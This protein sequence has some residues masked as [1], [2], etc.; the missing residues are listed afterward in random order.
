M[1]TIIHQSGIQGFV[2]SKKINTISVIENAFNSILP[3]KEGIFSGQYII[4]FNDFEYDLQIED[5]GSSV[6]IS[7]GT[8]SF[9]G[10][11][12]LILDLNESNISSLDVFAYDEDGVEYDIP[13]VEIRENNRVR[14]DL[15]TAIIQTTKDLTHIEIL[16]ISS[17]GIQND[18]DLVFYKTPE[19]IQRDVSFPYYNTYY[20]YYSG[21]DSKSGEPW[22]MCSIAT[23]PPADFALD[24][25]TSESCKIFGADVDF[26]R[27]EKLLLTTDG[28]HFTSFIL[29]ALD[30]GGTPIIEI[31]ITAPDENN[32]IEITIPTSE[33]VIEEIE[34]TSVENGDTSYAF[35]GE[36]EVVF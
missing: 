20:Y 7:S 19:N 2:A 24:W 1:G 6:Y 23:S 14:I 29:H 31:P 35:G 12:N 15:S 30:Y 8:L 3:L 5:S 11:K 27:V 26:L 9:G 21:G 22:V 32:E 28:I 4:G 10:I 33:S 13:P 25:N 18:I 17:S 34:F 16:D 36:V